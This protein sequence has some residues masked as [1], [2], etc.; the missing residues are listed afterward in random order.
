M[1][2]QA[3]GTPAPAAERPTVLAPIPAEVWRVAWVIVLG[4]FMANLDTS[5]VNVGLD[6]ISRD[7]RGSLSSVQWVTSG[8]LIA[9]A[10]ALPACAWLGR[11][12]GMGRLWLYALVGFTVTS[13]LCAAAADLPALIVLRVAQGIT[14]G[15]LLPAGQAVLGATAGP[16]RMGRVM[17]TVGLA[18]VLAPAIG[19]TV[20][21]LLI[22]SL[23][24]RWLFLVNV[25]I[26]LIAIAL[27]LRCVPSGERGT[28]GRFDL[29]GFILVGSGLP[30]L[31]YGITAASQDGTLTSPAVLATLLPGALGL[32]AFTCWSLRRRAPLLNL[33]LLTN[34]VY[35][36]AATLVFLTG[37]ALFGG[38]IILP[39]YYEL[40]RHKGVVATG[41]LMLA[42][43]A[44]AALSMPLGGRL[45]DRLGG[46]ITAV[47][48]LVITIAAT[49][50]F[51][52]LDASA[53]LAGVEAL[54][55]VRGIGISLAGV[56]AVAA[57]YASV[58][59]EHIPDA[60]AQVNIF[61][62]V[63][64]ALG[65]ALLVVILDKQGATTT[66][67]FHAVFWWLTAT[68]VLALITAVLLANKQRGPA[69]PNKRSGTV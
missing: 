23:S 32:A 60:A 56:P 34:R 64:G 33:R 12:L 49:V 25:P 44:G 26:G 21:G 39:L 37:A 54:Q 3:S 7:L 42:Y 63:G 35:S 22:D 4:A 24:W 43:G 19:P 8:Y 47:A 68:A 41:L 51:A 20:G 65:S 52:F 6:T 48:G 9:L 57:A 58:A 50:P 30:L 55:F 1:P 27:G 38:M 14:G 66:T 2:Q 45:T 36:A 59:R 53:S 31:V 28:A 67:A 62:R 17:N 10:G 46:G 11:H 13:G 18:V 61:Q 15:L 16:S 69:R 5:L 40:Y 29:P